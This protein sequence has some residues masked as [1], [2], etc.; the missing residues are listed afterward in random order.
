MDRS[1][2]PLTVLTRL[3]IF[4]AFAIVL[5]VP[6]T[7]RLVSPAP[8]PERNARTLVGIMDEAFATRPR[9]AWIEALES[10]AVMCSPANRYADVVNDPQTLANDYVT[11]VDH[12]TFGPTRIVGCP[13]HLSATPPDAQGYAPELG[14]HTEEILLAHGYSWDDLSQLREEGVI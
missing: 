10:E 8:A 2:L 11:T 9:N 4:G 12:P 6:L 3:A 1:T 5:G 13:L 7:M 14:Q